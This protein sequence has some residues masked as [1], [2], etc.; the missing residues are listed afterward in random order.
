[1]LEIINK[2]ERVS[3]AYR[4]YLK[5]NGLELDNTNIALIINFLDYHQF[6]IGIYTNFEG[7]DWIVDIG[8][9]HVGISNNRQDAEVLGIEEGFASLEN[10]LSTL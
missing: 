5:D 1:M 8:D 6:Y 4:A 2:Y 9:I 10:L 3:R 7:I